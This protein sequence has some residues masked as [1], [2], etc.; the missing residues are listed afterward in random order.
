MRQ[1][2]SPKC[3]ELD[4]SHLGAWHTASVK[5]S[6]GT[7]ETFFGSVRTGNP[8]KV[9]LRPGRPHRLRGAV[10]DAQRACGQGVAHRSLRGALSERTVSFE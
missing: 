9:F 7:P 5:R 10:R 6:M 2:Y 8:K 1:R 4:F 3:L